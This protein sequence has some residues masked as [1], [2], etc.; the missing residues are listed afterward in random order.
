MLFTSISWDCSFDAEDDGGGGGGSTDMQ[1]FAFGDLG[2]GELLPAGLA[3]TF[4]PAAFSSTNR[5][6]TRG[7]GY[8]VETTSQT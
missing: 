3:T 1:F 6:R 7:K 8:L 4:D 5:W 2:L